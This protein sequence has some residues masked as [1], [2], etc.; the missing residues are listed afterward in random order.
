MS[1]DTR[2]IVPLTT[3]PLEKRREQ[4]RIAREIAEWE[5]EHG[6]IRERDS[7]E[8][9]GY[10]PNVRDFRISTEQSKRAKKRPR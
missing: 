1:D 5:A 10:R 2:N 3:I 4:E 6:P 9:A 7:T 8:N